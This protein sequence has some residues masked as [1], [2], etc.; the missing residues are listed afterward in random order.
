[1]EEPE[2]DVEDAKEALQTLR[3][4]SQQ[5]NGVFPESKIIEYVRKRLCTMPC[6]N[7][8]YVLDGV[9]AKLTDA[10]EIFGRTSF[11]Y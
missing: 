7:Q 5:N 11:K 10:N 8:G 4:I 6:Q 1:M 3:E 2:D 9:P